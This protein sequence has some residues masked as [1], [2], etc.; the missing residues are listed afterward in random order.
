M[1]GKVSSTRHYI[2]EFD[3]ELINELFVGEIQTNL[4]IHKEAHKGSQLFFPVFE[5]I[6]NNLLLLVLP[7]KTGTLLCWRWD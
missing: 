5:F 1:L 3:N 7:L 2:N 6:T 4:Q